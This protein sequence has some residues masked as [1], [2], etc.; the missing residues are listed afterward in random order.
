MMQL[1]TPNH[2]GD[3]AD[4]IAEMH[5]MRYRVFKERLGWDVRVE[6][7]MEIDQYDAM[8]P[9]YLLQRALDGKLQGCVRLLPSNG[10]N[11][12]RDTFSSLLDGNP[13]PSDPWIWESSRFALELSP[14]LSR[15]D[16]GL[17]TA[18]YE[19][20]VGMIEFGLS[21]SLREIV[22]VT[23]VRIERILKRANWPLKRLGN[24]I[25]IGKTLAVAGSLEVSTDALARVKQVGGIVTRV[26]WEPV[27]LV[28]D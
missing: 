10:P 16:S 11:M 15:S 9:V 14:T 24:T 12:L 23:D 18:T 7:D 5:R 6:G 4:A 26:L 21:R 2:Y 25:T 17:A 3:F 8:D 22:T 28:A 1:I 13:C 27:A 20:F 19:L